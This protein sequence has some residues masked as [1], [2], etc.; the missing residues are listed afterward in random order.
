LIS[1]FKPGL[2]NY[3]DHG[4]DKPV[5]ITEDFLRNI[6]A[7]TSNVKLTDEHKKEVIGQIENFTYQD[8]SLQIQKPGDIDIQDK[9][10]SPVFE[11]NLVSYD[12]HYLAVDG[13]IREAGLTSTPRNHILYNSILNPNPEDDNMTEVNETLRKALEREQEQQETIGQLKAQLQSASSSLK[14]KQELETKLKDAEKEAE[15]GQ[16]KIDDLKKKADAYDELEKEKKEALIKELVGDDE[17]LG[18]ELE[19]LPYDKLRFLKES[20]IINQ[21]PKGVGSK[22]A[23]GLNDDGTK[24]KKKDE[25]SYEDWRKKQRTW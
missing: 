18:K 13:I 5:K 19:D 16:K 14:E 2:I 12:D 10:I 4:L 11:L 15:N 25:E 20:K 7:A 8:G 3:T 21:D 1:I 9:G 17:K 23:P 22:G 24:K 6:A